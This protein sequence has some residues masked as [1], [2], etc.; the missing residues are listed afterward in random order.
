MNSIN[1]YV[2][3]DEKYLEYVSDIL[4]NEEFLKLSNYTHHNSD[5]FQHSL[6]VSYYS[7]L[8]SRKFNLDSK[9]IARAALLHDF[10]LVDNLAI[11]KFK[12]FKTLFTHPRLAL[13]NSLKYYYL[14]D[15]ERNIIV[16]HM[17]PI[18]LDL[19]RYK[20]SILVDFVDNYI[21]IH[22]ALYAKKNELNAAY[23]FLSLF[24]FSILFRWK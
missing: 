18:G 22:E 15:M 13:E 17:F 7:Y 4:S 21:S 12:R 11:G 8:I 2:N 5:R 19:P 16:S 1:V 14:S 24:V 6:N 10:F 9:K 23:S 20:E 3:D